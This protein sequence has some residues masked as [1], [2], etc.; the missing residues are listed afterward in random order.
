MR[1]TTVIL[2]CFASQMAVQATSFVTIV[3]TVAAVSSVDVSTP[4]LDH[5]PF[6]QLA[7]ISRR[8]EVN[9][10]ETT[11]MTRIYL[12]SPYTT[13]VEI[14]LTP[15]SAG[16]SISDASGHVEPTESTKVK[17]T[18]VK[19]TKVKSTKIKST[20]STASMT[21]IHLTYPYTTV[22]DIP[23]TAL[24]SGY[25]EPT[26]KSIKSTNSTVSMT[27]YH[28]TSPYTT[29]VDI[30]VTA[31]RTEKS[32]KPVGFTT[33]TTSTTSTSTSSTSSS[34][35]STPPSACDIYPYPA[36]YCDDSSSTT[37]SATASSATASSSTK[38]RW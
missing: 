6:P 25:V 8:E 22:V 10:T 20:T 11:S 24:P 18:K 31:V 26:H 15:L 21:R 32:V 28:F 33:S 5:T 2:S 13:Y 4:A 23:L 14:P 35:T 3:K 19:S 29:D 38:T 27:R 1:F 9:L 12:T 16:K 17:S 30:P 36:E 34:T 7:S 37:S